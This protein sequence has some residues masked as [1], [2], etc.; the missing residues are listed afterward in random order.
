VFHRVGGC[1]GEPILRV[2]T[3]E[4]DD[5]GEAEVFDQSLGGVEEVVVIEEVPEDLRMDE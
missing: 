5:A 3:R 2:K 1:P 4:L